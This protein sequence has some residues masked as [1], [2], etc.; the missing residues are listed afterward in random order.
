MAT[1]PLRTLI[2]GIS[3][4]SVAQ[5]SSRTPRHQQ[6]FHFRQSSASLPHK[7]AVDRCTIRDDY[8]KHKAKVYS[9]NDY[10]RGEFCKRFRLPT[11]PLEQTTM[12][13]SNRARSHRTNRPVAIPPRSPGSESTASNIDGSDSTHWR[14][15][16]PAEN[17]SSLTSARQYR[18]RSLEYLRWEPSTLCSSSRTT[19]RSQIEPI[20][21]T[22]ILFETRFYAI[23]V[24]PETNLC[25]SECKGSP[26]NS[27]RTFSR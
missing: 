6:A 20:P 13:R 14:S 18:Q 9:D 23:F 5:E 11:W 8:H 17:E 19:R 7:N 24:R 27:I 16:M 3:P 1:T 21:D 25:Q 22:F 2:C 12:T 15:T 4:I 26:R 10:C